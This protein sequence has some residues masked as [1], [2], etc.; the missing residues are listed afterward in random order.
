MR[1]LP[2]QLG[3]TIK[4]LNLIGYSQFTL[5][6]ITKGRVQ[7]NVKVWSLTNKGGVSRNQTPIANFIS[8]LD[9]LFALT[10]VQF[11][12]KLKG[13]IG[14]PFRPPEW[15][16]AIFLLLKICFERYTLHQQKKWVKHCNKEIILKLRGGSVRYGQRPYFYIFWTL[17]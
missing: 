17:P 15:V 4:K 13:I 16:M 2:V 3:V 1:L 9:W 8:F 14:R 12:E 11:M 6:L 10:C 7:K 5:T